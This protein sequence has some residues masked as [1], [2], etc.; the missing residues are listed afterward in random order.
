MFT[1]AISFL[2]FAASSFELLSSALLLYTTQRVGAD[3]YGG[4]GKDYY[5]DEKAIRGFL[6]DQMQLENS[7]VKDF[8][9]TSAPFGKIMDDVSDDGFD[10]VNAFRDISNF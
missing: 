3:I 5:L 6:N 8:C 10:F 1:L 7:P 4:A 2:I 9:F